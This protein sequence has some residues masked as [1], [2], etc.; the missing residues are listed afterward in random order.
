MTIYIF[1][2]ESNLTNSAIGFFLKFN[3]PNIKALLL[4]ST[5]FLID[6]NLSIQLDS[7]EFRKLRVFVGF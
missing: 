1:M 7:L 3:F 2:E 4:I 5:F 6:K